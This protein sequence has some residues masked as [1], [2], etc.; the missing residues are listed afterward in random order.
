MII[1]AEYTIKER[2]EVNGALLKLLKDATCFSPRRFYRPTFTISLFF[3]L[4]TEMHLY[5]FYIELYSLEAILMN[6][7]EFTFPSVCDI[8]KGTI[9]TKKLL[10]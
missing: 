8:I 3:F 10:R 9:I 6:F 4:C 5:H 2:S 1:S 7:I